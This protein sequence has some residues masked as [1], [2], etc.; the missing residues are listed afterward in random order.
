LRDAI[1]GEGGVRTPRVFVSARDGEGLDALR[2][3]LAEVLASA[4]DLNP[5][6]QAASEVSE[7][8]SAPLVDNPLSAIFH[9][10]ASP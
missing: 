8:P 1:E 6:P 9:S 5:A 2:Q 10:H 4:A 7:Q 3:L